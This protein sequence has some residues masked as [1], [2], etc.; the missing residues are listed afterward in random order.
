M[1]S[2]APSPKSEEKERAANAPGLGNNF[3]YARS[4]AS[5]SPL[6]LG[7][8]D[9]GESTGSRMMTSGGS[10]TI[11]LP[12]RFFVL[13][14]GDEGSFLSGHFSSSSSFLPRRRLHLHHHH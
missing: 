2:A 1:I 4:S 11:I 5:M 10:T 3:T 13:S 14:M 7:C 8:Y 6:Y 9:A 12:A